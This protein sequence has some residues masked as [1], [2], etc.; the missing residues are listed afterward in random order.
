MEELSEL[1]WR[2]LIDAIQSGKCI[3]ILGP[4]AALDK[5]TGQ[6]VPITKILASKLIGKM[7]TEGSPLKM[8]DPL[9]VSQA[10]YNHLRQNKKDRRY[11]EI[12]VKDFYTEHSNKTSKVHLDLACLPF[13]LCVIA[14]H[15]KYLENAFVKKGKSPIVEYYDFQK[16][17][18]DTL[19]TQEN[20]S[21]QNPVIYGLSGSYDNP[22]SLVLTET[23]LL[24]F[25]VKITQNTP[26]LSDYIREKFADPDTSFLFVGF[27]LQQWY[28]RILLHVLKASG[29]SLSSVA[30]ESEDFLLSQGRDKTVIFYGNEYSLQFCYPSIEK[31][32]SDLAKIYQQEGVKPE[33][34]VEVPDGAAKAFLCHCSNDHADVAKLEKKLKQRG[35][36]TWLDRQNLRGGDRWDS[37]IEKVIGNEVDYVLILQTPDMVSRNESYFYK[38]IKEALE[39]NKRFSQE[40][41]FII[42][43]MLKRCNPLSDLIGFNCIDLMKPDG[44][45]ELVQAIDEDWK[46]RS[47]KKKD[48]GGNGQ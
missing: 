44:I 32:T 8:D 33:L 22:Q 21:D 28:L 15:D 43:C 7:G 34:P 5:S 30:I 4:D 11:L 24:D 13:S 18:P 37:V 40:I 1:D 20:P 29:H 25:L 47:S 26:P 2:C 46:T 10:Y 3:L 9:H 35:I 42:P 39:R 38:E 16:G 23:D 17:R 45:D 12:E 27:G 6:Q 36:D 14:C 41:R 48:T 19:L 31:F